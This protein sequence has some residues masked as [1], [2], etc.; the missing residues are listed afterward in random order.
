MV[1]EVRNDRLRRVSEALRRERRHGEA[2]DLGQPFRARIQVK[3][4]VR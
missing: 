2:V 4:L 3:N 1:A